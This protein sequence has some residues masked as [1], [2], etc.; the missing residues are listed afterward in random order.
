MNKAALE[1]RLQQ[2][3]LSLSQYEHALALLGL[4]SVGVE[5]ARMDE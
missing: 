1:Q 5:T 4:G 2:I 3:A